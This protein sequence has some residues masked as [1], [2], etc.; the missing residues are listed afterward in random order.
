LAFIL[1][2]VPA[3]FGLV[4]LLAWSQRGGPEAVCSVGLIG[5]MMC[6]CFDVADNCSVVACP[7]NDPLM[8]SVG[9]VVS[10]ALAAAGVL[11]LAHRLGRQRR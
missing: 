3:S 1:I 5:L 9:W 6:A 2:A 4:G 11:A 8:L 7:E 10:A